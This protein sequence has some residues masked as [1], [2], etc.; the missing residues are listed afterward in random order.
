[1]YIY[2]A[3]VQLIVEVSSAHTRT[4]AQVLTHTK[5][6]RLAKVLSHTYYIQT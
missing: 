3:L 5:V 2:G 1:M 6:H 4:Y